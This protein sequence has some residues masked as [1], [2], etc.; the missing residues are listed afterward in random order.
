MVKSIKTVIKKVNGGILCSLALSFLIFIYAPLE[1]YLVNQDDFWFD[2]YTIFPY[3]MGMFLISCTVCIA[4]LIGIR[5]IRVQI[6]ESILSA[7]FAVFIATYV[8]GT[9]LSSN[10]PPLDG[11]NKIG[12]A[13]V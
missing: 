12:R 3:L 1:L 6:Y 13:H 4:V 2:I 8:Q 10:L 7:L 5:I 11:R 9:F